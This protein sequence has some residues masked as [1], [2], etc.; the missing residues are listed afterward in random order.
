MVS[1][2]R[3]L[4]NSNNSIPLRSLNSDSVSAGSMR[5]NVAV[6]AARQQANQQALIRDTPKGPL[7]RLRGKQPPL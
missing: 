7:Y 2:R 1:S 5:P 4:S 6:A 3:T